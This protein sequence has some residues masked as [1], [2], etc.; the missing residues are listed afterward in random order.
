MNSFTFI[1]FLLLVP[2]SFFIPL[3]LDIQHYIIIVQFFTFSFSLV[4]NLKRTS[5]LSDTKASLN[6]VRSFFQLYVLETRTL[7]HDQLQKPSNWI[8]FS[9]VCYFHS[10]NRAFVYRFRFVSK[11]STSWW[12]FFDCCL[13]YSFKILCKY[14]EE[15]ANLF[16]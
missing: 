2:L 13:L 15:W 1:W 16:C 3:V 11:W 9:I 8:V 7:L 5:S 14:E 6:V 4:R 10:F 12:D